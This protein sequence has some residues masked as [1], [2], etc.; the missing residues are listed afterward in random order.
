MNIAIFWHIGSCSPYTNRSFGEIY[1]FHLQGRKSAKEESTVQQP[2]Y[3][4]LSDFLL[5]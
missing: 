5:G 4:P 2:S 3:L 1:Y